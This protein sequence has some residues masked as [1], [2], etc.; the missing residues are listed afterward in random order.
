[1]Y[2]TEQTYI[3]RQCLDGSVYTIIFFTVDS[4]SSN[5]DL[6]EFKSM[7]RVTQEGKARFEH[8]SA[9]GKLIKYSNLV[10]QISLKGNRQVIRKSNLKRQLKVFKTRLHFIILTILANLSPLQDSFSF[11][12]FFD[13]FVKDVVRKII[14]N[15]KIKSYRCLWKCQVSQYCQDNEV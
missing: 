15:N 3:V 5:K 8:V 10:K 12:Y 11:S 2:R 13:K 9:Q 1:M 4:S 6:S 7:I 14:S